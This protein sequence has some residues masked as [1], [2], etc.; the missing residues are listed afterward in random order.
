[1]I[2]AIRNQHGNYITEIYI[3]DEII[4]ML[5][6]AKDHC[7]VDGV[8]ITLDSDFRKDGVRETVVEIEGI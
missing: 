4:D 5:E 6:K 3:R 7:Y 2:H 8:K 1:M